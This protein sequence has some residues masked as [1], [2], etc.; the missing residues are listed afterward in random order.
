M[1][2][3]AFKY[4]NKGHVDYIEEFINEMNRQAQKLRLKNCCF[5]NPHGLS[6]KSNH[7]S[8]SDVAILMYYAMKYELIE[9]ITNK[10]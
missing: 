4:P 7:A 6:Q 9:E 1:I 5:I 2:K 8:A 10:M 3:E